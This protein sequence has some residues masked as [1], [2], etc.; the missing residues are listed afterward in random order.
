MKNSSLSCRAPPAVYGITQCCYLPVCHPAQVNMPYFNHSQTGRYLIYLQWRDGRLRSADRICAMFSNRIGL[1]LP[2][3][4]FCDRFCRSR[5]YANA[6]GGVGLRWMS[7]QN[8]EIAISVLDSG[9][10]SEI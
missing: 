8:R 10:Q 6:A 4:G 2:C 9:L 1:L 3:Y 7:R 5:L